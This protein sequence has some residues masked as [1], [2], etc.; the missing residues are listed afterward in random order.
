MKIY[1]VVKKST[2]EE[3]VGTLF[4]AFRSKEAAQEQIDRNPSCDFY[5]DVFTLSEETDQ[6]WLLLEGDY[7][8]QTIKSVHA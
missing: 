5:P 1:V 2:K 7:G 8:A 4:G 6:V 3:G